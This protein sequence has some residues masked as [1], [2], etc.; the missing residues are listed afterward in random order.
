MVY[1]TF[2]VCKSGGFKVVPKGNLKVDLMELAGKFE[3][4]KMKTNTILVVGIGNARVSIYP[5]GKII[6][7]DCSEDEGEEIAAEVYKMIKD[8]IA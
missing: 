7:H 3:D 1:Y 8:V 2:S 6:L 5:S 4:V